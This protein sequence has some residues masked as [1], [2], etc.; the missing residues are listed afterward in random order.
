MAS[1]LINRVVHIK[2]KVKNAGGRQRDNFLSLN[3][4]LT[5]PPQNSD[6]PSTSTHAP[7]EDLANLSERVK[8]LESQLQASRRV[9]RE[10]QQENPTPK[11]RKRTAKHYSKRHIRRLKKQRIEECAAALSWLENDGL[12]PVSVT[13]LNTETK[14]V[15]NIMVRKDLE[16]ALQLNG[17]ELGE[18]EADL[19]SMML[20]VKDKYN[21]SGSAYHEL[22]SLCREMQRHFRL[23][24]RIAELNSKWNIVPTP[25]GTI[26]V[27][28]RLQERLTTCLER[29]VS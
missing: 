2:R 12:T 14:E 8:S 28:Q 21:I 25:E 23:K 17:E 11:R 5:L 18:Q 13:V 10:I 19:V 6:T 4:T 15:E 20:Y 3:W 27:Q 1:V 26:G 9:L 29:L 7:A 22:A 16:T 24:E